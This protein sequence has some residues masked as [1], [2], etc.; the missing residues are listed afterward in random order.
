[1]K[2]REVITVEYSTAQRNM[3][4]ST[5]LALLPN[6]TNMRIL[7]FSRK[8]VTMKIFKDSTIIYGK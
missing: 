7:P 3:E 6:A 1:V 2:I 4:V 8:T 5:L